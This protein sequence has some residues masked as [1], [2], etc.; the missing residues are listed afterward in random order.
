MLDDPGLLAG[1]PTASATPHTLLSALSTELDNHNVD[2]KIRLRL[3]HLIA[4]LRLNHLTKRPADAPIVSSD[5]KNPP[6]AL[7][8]LQDA[9][10][11]PGGSSETRRDASASTSP[12]LPDSQNPAS[13]SMGGYRAAA[14]CNATLNNPPVQPE[15]EQQQPVDPP[16]L[17]GQEARSLSSESSWELV[18]AGKL[19]KVLETFVSTLTARLER[20]E[21]NK[22]A[23]LATDVSGPPPAAPTS[24]AA[25]AA[26]AAPLPTPA[27]PAPP[28][29]PAKPAAREPVVISTSTLAS[30]HPLR[31]LPPARLLTAIRSLLPLV[32]PS[33]LVHATRLER[34][35]VLV[36]ASSPSAASLL[37]R[38]VASSLAGASAAAP[39]EKAVAVVHHVPVDA[40]EEEM[41]A[42]AMEWAEVGEEEMRAVRRLG[43]KPGA[44]YCSWLVELW[45]T[46]AVTRF[47]SIGLRKLRE[48]EGVWVEVERGLSRGELRERR[49]KKEAHL[50]TL[51]DQ[52][53]AFPALSPELFGPPRAQ[54]TPSPTPPSSPSRPRTPPAATAV[55]PLPAPTLPNS[56]RTVSAAEADSSSIETTVLHIDEAELPPSRQPPPAANASWDDESVEY[57]GAGARVVANAGMPEAEREWRRKM[58]PS[59]FRGPLP[60]FSV[61][62]GCF[63]DE[64]ASDAVEEGAERAREAAD[65]AKAAAEERVKVAAGEVEGEREGE[66]SAGGG[67][68]GEHC[69]EES[70]E[71]A[72]EGEEEL[73]AEE[74]VKP[75]PAGAKRGQNRPPTPIPAAYPY[76]HAPDD[77]LTLG[78]GPILPPPRAPFRPSS[79]LTR[80]LASPACRSVDLLLLQEP[81]FPLPPLSHGWSA[82]PSPSLPPQADGRPT[83]VRSVALIPARRASSSRLLPLASPDT[84]VVKVELRGETRV[85]V[86]GVY[87]ASAADP[88]HN[89]AVEEDLPRALALLPPPPHLL[90]AGDFNLHHPLWER[91]R[92]SAP[93][94]AAE[95]LVS[96]LN[97]ASLSPLLMPG[98]TT[99]FGHNGAAEGCN[100]LFFALEGMVERV[101]SC[102]VDEELVS[103]S[104]HLPLRAIF[105]K[106]PA[107]PPPPPAPL[108]F[109]KTDL[110]SALLAY[111]IFSSLLPPPPSLDTL[112]DLEKEAERL[113]SIASYAAL[114]AVPLALPGSRPRAYEWWC[115]EIASASEVPIA[116]DDPPTMP[117]GTALTTMTEEEV[118]KRR[119][120]MAETKS[121]KEK[122]GSP[123]PA[124]S[125]HP[126]P[127]PSPSPAPSPAAAMP[128]P[129]LREEEVRTALFSSRPFAAPGA[130]ELPNHFLQLLWPLLR[131]R[132]VP[133]YASLLR[134]G[135]L[136]AAWRDAVGLVLRKPKKP[137]YSVAKAYRLIAFERTLA[138]CVEKVV[139]R[140][141]AFLSKEYE[142]LDEMHF[143]GRRRRSAEDELVCAADWIKR[144]WRHGY[145]VVG[146]A[147]DL[148]FAFPSVDA[149]ALDADLEDAGVPAPARR[150]LLTWQSGRSCELRLGDARA[151]SEQRGLPQGSPLSPLAFCV[152]NSGALRAGRTEDSEAY[153]WIDDLNLF[154]RGRS[155][156]EAVSRVNKEIAPKLEGWARSHSASFEPQKTTVTIFAPPRKAIPL[157]PPPIVLCGED[158]PY[159]PEMTILGGVFDTHLSFLP[160]IARCARNA[161]AA[162]NA[163]ACTMGARHGFRPALAKTLYEAVV[164]PRLLWAGALWWKEEGAEGKMAVLR[165]VQKEGARLVSG[166]F[167]TAAREALEVEAGLAPL[168]H[169]LRL[170]HLKLALR[171][172]SAPPSLP[173]HAPTQLTL[174]RPSPPHP[175]PLH[176]AL[177]SP[178]L[179][180]N[181]RLE[182]I[183][184]DP[185][186][187]WEEEPSVA[188]VIAESKEASVAMHERAA[189]AAEEGDVLVYT[190]GSLM[191]GE[192][193][194]GVMFE[195]KSA[196]GESLRAGRSRELGQYQG[197]YQGE[198]EALRIAFTSI[199]TFL[200]PSSTA[201]VRIFAD[202][203]SAVSLP[204]DPRPTSAQH[205]R[206]AI[207]QAAHA[208]NATH[209]YVRVR[210]Y[211][212]AGHAE[213]AGNE[214]ADA[215]A[216]RG[217]GEGRAPPME[218]A[219]RRKGVT[220]P[221]EA[222]EHSL[223]SLEEKVSEWWE[224]GGSSSL[225]HA[226]RGRVANASEAAAVDSEGRMG[227]G[228]DVPKSTTG[229]LQAAKEALRARWEK[230]WAAA[231]VGARLRAVDASSPFSPFR[232]LLRTLPRPQASR[233][234]RLRTDFSPLAAALHRAHLHPDGLCAC[235]ERETR[236][237][238]LL[239]CPLYALP[240]RALLR[241][242]R[243][244]DLPPLR[245]LL[246]TVAFARP[247]LRFINATDRFPRFYVAVE[248]EDEG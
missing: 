178:L 54:S 97:D 115:E 216:R 4:L 107:P 110:E 82:L 76:T 233:L 202:N 180:R 17:L 60:S 55:S 45:D 113:T 61:L 157:A 59:P 118:M 128:W 159:A 177:A 241:E 66:G 196:G 235:G 24:Y 162:L 93:S 137:D 195:V 1:L 77:T 193:G 133:L 9:S 35:D 217:A 165:A 149:S 112:A 25:R 101:V 221:R 136:P 210:L 46:S 50:Q 234:T 100:D 36:A 182:T 238:F 111:R 232:R 34:G 132:L 198:L 248:E 37:R 164:V 68:E 168:E 163:V 91:E 14:A 84:V 219:P 171:A 43:V 19:T 52:H 138:K 215:L 179:P 31:V 243:L 98:T 207:R 79:V 183:L 108:R 23:S 223:D 65:A 53:G 127:S 156:E 109:R 73:A 63:M 88:L 242:L 152:Y 29:M 12:V 72:E 236:E 67:E 71:E 151:R 18:G 240:R 57:D 141:L 42:K 145:V 119:E 155:V 95:T 89:R 74:V 80:L 224:E 226:R 38:A 124:A 139:T 153:G 51:R 237:H 167:G 86:V 56:S 106:S 8:A 135:H 44:R 122:G 83:R 230:E 120:K 78:A 201:R 147:L 94:P 104:D 49:E 218:R 245:A 225:L 114:A 209:P 189:A 28:P 10:I 212:V 200:D 103:G 213:V 197:V 206:L 186:A 208:L 246:S 228:L 247:L 7:S 125:P 192:T 161:S 194:A 87:N 2:P 146:V 26:A 16:P 102:G 130:N 58:G 144:Q 90:L 33:S 173:L 184:P 47:V 117:M 30:D 172:L 160:H 27:P 203:Q 176:A 231:P 143:G 22:F 121:R 154:A 126:T 5:P 32:P 211:W 62:K 11:S 116:T 41:K 244:R 99:F 191:E 181:T 21:N 134:P 158:L 239:S 214:E 204:F 140:R 174:A 69:E 229:V 75:K 6:A 64:S 227:G 150:F 148:A 169:R 48:E 205:L 188:I 3:D 166:G 15:V 185:V 170:T 131:R 220:M 105:S 187:P 40:E 13:T 175:S 199:P 92:T 85:R 81:P 222:I 96:T 39:P 123:S 70:G 142:I 20:L 129:E 190:D